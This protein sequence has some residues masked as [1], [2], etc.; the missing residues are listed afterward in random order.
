MDVSYLEPPWRKLNYLVE[1]EKQSLSSLKATSH[2]FSSLLSIF[3]FQTLRVHLHCVKT[4]D[5]AKTC[6]QTIQ[7]IDV[8]CVTAIH[9]FRVH[10]RH[11]R[12]KETSQ[13]HKSTCD[14]LML[15]NSTKNSPIAV[16]W[17]P[18]LLA[19]WIDK[20]TFQ[21]VRLTWKG[22]KLNVLIGDKISFVGAAHLTRGSRSCSWAFYRSPPC[23]IVGS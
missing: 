14:T 4:A 22:P 23:T 11:V 7:L 15:L 13:R 8:A 18:Q 19:N 2:Q 16:G 1:Y 21:K 20:K 12:W 6:F 3:K 5:F 17:N 9:L 10:K